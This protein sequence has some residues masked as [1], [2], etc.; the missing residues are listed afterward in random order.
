MPYC[1]VTIWENPNQKRI[2]DVTGTTGTFEC[3]NPKC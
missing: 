1:K 2:A 3:I